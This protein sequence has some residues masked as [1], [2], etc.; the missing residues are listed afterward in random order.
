M[1]AQ[2]VAIGVELESDKAEM[3]VQQTL[4]LDRPWRERRDMLSGILSA[5]SV[6]D[7]QRVVRNLDQRFE[8]LADIDDFEIVCGIA[9]HI[10]VEIPR[11]GAIRRCGLR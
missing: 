5:A 4:N 6:E 7:R 11:D 1:A 2:M 9:E 10:G 3:L 8:E